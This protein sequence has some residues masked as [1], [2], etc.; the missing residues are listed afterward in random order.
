[1]LFVSYVLFYIGCIRLPP[2][3]FSYEKKFGK[4]TK[5]I[6]DGIS[7]FSAQKKEDVTIS[8][9]DGTRLVAQYL[10]ARNSKGTILLFHG[11][12]AQSFTDFSCAYKMY[13]D[14]GFSILNVTQRSHGLSGG[15]YITFG[16]KE[17]FDCYDWVL[18][19]NDRFG[20][21]SDIFLGGMSMG[22]STVLMAAGMSLPPN[23]RGIIADSGFSCPYDEFAH[24]LKRIHC[25]VH[26]FA[27]IANVYAQ[28]LAG[29]RFDEYSTVEAMKTN[30]IPILFIHGEADNFVPVKF[31]LESYDACIAE[32]TLV[33]VADAGHGMAYLFDTSG[34]QKELFAFLSKNSTA[35]L[36]ILT[37][38]YSDVLFDAP[39]DEEMPVSPEAPTELVDPPLVQEPIASERPE[40]AGQPI[41]EPAEDISG[42]N[43]LLDEIRR[44]DNL[45]DEDMK[46]WDSW[47]P[48]DLDDEENSI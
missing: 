43:S 8:A 45:T 19:V 35:D 9:R 40:P 42:L 28:V 4:H 34:C 29:F 48:L 37:P 1:M 32:K 22:A 6:E 2:K 44:S 36:E 24:V 12:R 21:A 25:P 31:S 18:Y 41:P 3:K 27:D 16:V 33:T 30:K 38:I 5:T 39:V 7:W 10:P 23:V 14:L 20:T 47:N 11:Y 46:L 26:P 17:R 15:T 13:H